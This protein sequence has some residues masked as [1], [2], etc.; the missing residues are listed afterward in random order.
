MRAFAVAAVASFLAAACFTVH[1][2]PAAKLFRIG[3]VLPYAADEL[4]L[5]KANLQGPF[6]EAMRE[7]GWIE[8][9]NVEFLARAS[10]GIDELVRLPVDVLVT[11]GE[12]EAAMKAP[13]TLPIVAHILDTAFRVEDVKSLSRPGPNVTGIVSEG[14]AG[15]ASK[16]LAF[17]KEAA[18]IKRVARLYLSQPL[19]F[20]SE[21]ELHPEYRTT[22]RAL[23][24]E[25]F[26][27]WASNPEELRTVF[28]EL[29]RRGNVGLV[30][31]PA[32][33]RPG[34]EARWDALLELVSRYRVPAIYDLPRAV[35]DGG[36]MSYGEDFAAPTRR[37]SYFVDRILKGAKVADLPLEQVNQFE[38]VVNLK[39]A[40]SIGLKL[41]DSILLRADRVI[42]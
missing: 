18:P 2:Q 32:S 41:P 22:A 14:T 40:R 23:G 39:A 27:V 4:L 25:I 28:A 1:G 26:P 16:R 9:R 21:S 17:L 11:F 13:R 36:L 29:A 37:L 12:Y 6:E 33:R 34:L 42:R 3:I 15:L 30:V 20:G 24:L 31:S 8:G 19:R 7:R 5:K 10:S 38:M 35:D